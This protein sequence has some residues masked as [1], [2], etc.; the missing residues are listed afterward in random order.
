MFAENL[1]CLSEYYNPYSFQHINLTLTLLRC[2]FHF[3]KKA[4]ECWKEFALIIVYEL[5]IILPFHNFL[6][7]QHIFLSFDFP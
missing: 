1:N 2:S 7:R 5:K 3:H 4:V 6:T